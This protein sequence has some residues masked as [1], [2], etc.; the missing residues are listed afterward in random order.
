M[1]AVA[2]GLFIVSGV[3][4]NAFETMGDL[5]G[6]R[7][8]HPDAVA[9]AGYGLV[10]A[11]L[12][13]FARERA[14]DQNPRAHSGVLLDGLIA[15]LALAGL[16]WAFIVEPLLHQSGAPLPV[17]LVITAYPVMSIFMVVVT[18][19]IVFDTGQEQAPSYWFM[20]IAMVCTFVGDVTYLLEDTKQIDVAPQLLDLPYV[21]A[22]VFAGAA[23]MH[24]SMRQ[25]TEPTMRAISPAYRTRIIFVAVG[26]LTPALLTLRASSAHESDRVILCTLMLAMT[27]AAIM[28]IVQAL[29]SAHRSESQLAFQAMH[30]RLTG[31]PN[32]LMMEMHLSELL[33]RPP[34]D[35]IQVAVLYLDLD[36]FKLI[37][38][39]LGHSQGDILLKEVSERLRGSIRPEDL[40]TRVGGDEFMVILG[41][42][43]SA[44]QVLEVA[45]RLRACLNPPFVIGGMSFHV[46]ASI[47]IAF[48]SRDDAYATAEALIRDSDTAMYEAK[49]AGRDAVAVFD[50]SMR[51]RVTERVELES[52]LRNAVARR[53]LHL[54]YQPIL[55]LPLATPIGM[56][57]L[58]RWTH[59]TH[60]VISPAKFI[61]LAEESGIIVEIG[62]W[63]LEE[64]IGQL[65][66]WARQSP[67]MADLY[68]S[69]N[70]SAAQLH[71]EQIV[72]RVAD[73]LTIHGVRASSLCLE[74]TES[75]VME[76][77]DSAAATLARFRELGIQTAID[78]FGCEYSSLAYLS[79]LPFTSLKIDQSFVRNL[80][81][82]DSADATLIASIVAMAQALDITTVAEGVETAEQVERIAA[83]GC[84]SVQGY[85]YSRPVG[86]DRLLEVVASL[87]APRLT[88]VHT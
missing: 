8:L 15:A 16:A 28:R 23:A 34:V 54:V 53:Q 62:N 14:R 64:S 46:S 52:D 48:T 4:R 76:D 57:A 77:H 21:S 68:L 11:G 22:F 10:A 80:E 2:I 19:R 75:V 27:A 67:H 5:T 43:V 82:Q 79:R 81:Q 26:L 49:D 70:L 35:D 74:L 20:L 24:P 40:V 37:N 25:L 39:T 87:G 29:G 84:D 85:F 61:P 18:L 73:L 38:D 47:G 78:D 69:V 6:D 13:G 3:A 56:E 63:V 30:D 51:A 32:R 1:I 45:N 44:S 58:V 88:L 50:D 55:R 86:G 83:L 66:Q 7:A 31:L 42:A 59:P 60:G 36:R 9:L 71:D 72:Q 33:R 65:A 12:L 17:M 41:S